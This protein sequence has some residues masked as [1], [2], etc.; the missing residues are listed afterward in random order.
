MIEANSHKTFFAIFNDIFPPDARYGEIKKQHSHLIICWAADGNDNYNNTSSRNECELNPKK[1]EYGKKEEA[2]EC[3]IINEPVYTENEN[4]DTTVL[5]NDMARIVFS[6]LF[7]RI[8]EF[9]HDMSLDKLFQL[10][11]TCDKMLVLVIKDEVKND[12]P[13]PKEF[14][15]PMLQTK[16]AIQTVLPPPQPL[17]QP[18]HDN[19]NNTAQA[20]T[21]QQQPVEN[22]NLK[23]VSIKPELESEFEFKVDKNQDD[24]GSIEL[25]DSDD[26]DDNGKHNDDDDGDSGGSESDVDMYSKNMCAGETNMS[27]ADN[28]SVDNMS[29]DSTLPSAFQRAN[30]GTPKIKRQ[31][32]AHERRPISPSSTS[33]HS[34]NQ[35]FSH[36]ATI[37]E[38]PTHPH[39]HNQTT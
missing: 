2:P 3:G 20:T 30:I 14:I 9:F 24:N 16:F 35:T 19:R 17:S 32:C 5:M 15:F 12:Y 4:D 18:P 28:M 21:T 13:N 25:Y 7:V 22:F 6:H 27:R 34:F 1:D 26:D 10:T 36:R 38:T 11:H 39:H 31:K 37:D 29:L 33:M 8:N 23:D